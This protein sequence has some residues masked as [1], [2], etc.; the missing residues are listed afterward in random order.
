MNGMK[1]S[2]EWGTVCVQPALQMNADR[3]VLST[4]RHW[5]Q[6]KYAC[7]KTAI[8]LSPFSKPKHVNAMVLCW[9]TSVALNCADNPP[10]SWLGCAS[11]FWFT[12]QSLST[13]WLSRSSFYSCRHTPNL[14][15]PYCVK[16]SNDSRALFELAEVSSAALCTLHSMRVKYETLLEHVGSEACCSHNSLPSAWE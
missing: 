7:C 6:Y 5:A 3:Q 4:L 11:Y 12:F 14:S 15:W 8:W 10:E 13:R 2:N 9:E 16:C 1:D